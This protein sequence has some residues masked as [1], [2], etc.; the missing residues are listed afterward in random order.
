MQEPFMET[1]IIGTLGIY[2]TQAYHGRFADGSSRVANRGLCDLVQSSIVH[3]IRSLFEPK[4]SRRGMWDQRYFEAWTPRVPAMLLELLSHENFAD[5]RY[6]MIL[7]SNLQSAEP[8][9]KAF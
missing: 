9:I 5:M 2:D 3:D 1:S 4:W 7:A 8:Y 6:G